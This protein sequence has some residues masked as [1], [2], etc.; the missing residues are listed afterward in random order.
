[1]KIN[2]ILSNL[3]PA[4]ETVNC[5]F[6]PSSLRDQLAQQL[7]T[8]EADVQTFVDD[9]NSSQLDKGKLIDFPNM[10]EAFTTLMSLVDQFSTPSG[11]ATPSEL[12]ALP[13][14]ENTLKVEYGSISDLMSGDE[15]DFVL[16]AQEA[17]SFKIYLEKTLK[18]Q[19][20]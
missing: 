9:I 20:Q 19:I 11:G 12:L 7:N 4:S 16:A 13:G 10:T 14:I 18:P 2:S 3:T 1:M 8:L 5:E 15:S 6:T 17:S